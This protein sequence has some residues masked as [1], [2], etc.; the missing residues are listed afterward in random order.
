MEHQGGAGHGKARS[1]GIKRRGELPHNNARKRFHF[2]YIINGGND[3][4]VG[5][6]HRM[7]LKT[8][9]KIWCNSTSTN[10]IGATHRDQ[11][12]L[13]PSGGITARGYSYCREMR[14]WKCTEGRIGGGGG[15]R[16]FDAKG[17][18]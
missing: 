13:K 10:T 8:A 14:C 3:K 15:V 18:K 12:T 17:K 2:V 16:Y 1:M 9:H 6:K 7:V 5:S 11:T 4:L